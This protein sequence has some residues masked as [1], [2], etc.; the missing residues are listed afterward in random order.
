MIYI[1]FKNLNK[2]EFVYDAVFQRMK[3]LVDKFP[4]LNNSRML[5]TVEMENSPS[6]AG[7]DSYKVQLFI[8][9]GRFNGIVVKKSDSNIYRAIADLADH[10]LEK[11]NR[12]GDR[13]RVTNISR[14]RRFLEKLNFENKFSDFDE[15][16]EPSVPNKNPA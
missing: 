13:E 4:A 5:V 12:A 11:L 16:I 7:A 14:Q 9:K 2:S 10:M 6:Q 15:D 1:K 8:S 3:S